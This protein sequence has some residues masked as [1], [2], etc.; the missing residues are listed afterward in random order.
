M[1]DD[2]FDAR[3]QSG[4]SR[5]TSCGRRRPRAASRATWPC[6]RRATRKAVGPVRSSRLLLHRLGGRVALG[7]RPRRAARRRRMALLRSSKGKGTVVYDADGFRYEGRYLW[8]I[9]YPVRAAQ[10]VHG[11]EEPPADR[12]RRS[13]RRR[14]R[15]RVA[16]E[17]R[18]R[19]AARAAPGGRL[20]LVVPYLANKITYKYDRKT[21]LL[22]A[23]GDRRG[24]AVRRDRRRSPGRAQERRRDGRS[25]SC[26]STTARRSTGSRR[27]SRARASAW[28]STNG[29][30][31]KGEWRKKTFN[32]PD[33]LLRQ[34]RQRRSR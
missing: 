3:P 14:S 27:S 22:P 34:E 25:P 17:V 24:E 7:L 23:V 15:S 30:T 4:L 1:I 29:K 20:D 10:H 21:Q 33:P 32:G 26:R 8:R 16:L 19:R 11:R 28:I 2:Q 13:A 6:S 31:I 9:T 18:A 5:P 12:A